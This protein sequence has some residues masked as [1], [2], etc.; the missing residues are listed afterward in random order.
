MSTGAPP[1]LLDVRDLRAYFF[2]RYGV[3][4]AVDG[5][6]FVVY[7]AETLGI[8]G[9][10]GSG[11]S[12]TAL[13]IVRALPRPAGR[14][15]SGAIH[16]EGRDLLRVSDA[17][18]RRLRGR[19]IGTILQDP[20]MSLDPVFSIGDQVG[21]PLRWHLGM[22]GAARRERVIQLLREVRIAMPSVRVTEYP[23]Q[24]S[25]GMRQRIVGA[26][27]IAC[28]PKLLIADE[29]TTALDV[30]IQAQ[31]LDLLADLKATHGLAMILITHD[32]GVVARVCD[33]VAVMYGGRIVE[34]APVRELLAS[35][36]HPYTQALVG[37]VP[38]VTE[39][40]EDLDAID[41]QPPDVRRLPAGCTFHPR[42]RYA[43]ERCRAEYPREAEVNP[44]HRVKCWLHAGGGS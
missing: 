37:S 18:M 9:E 34:T 13:S 23:H 41:G 1:P 22:S 6:S 2:T 12:V 3:G 39:R 21:E 27:A 31:F 17:E 24:M 40:R 16:F 14:I 11:K 4:K 19:R 43:S 29:P 25:G 38:R 35:P 42:C 36:A 26:M 10:S 15:V 30:T 28:A 44:G 7:E 5:V 32:L 20:M 33:R 8:V